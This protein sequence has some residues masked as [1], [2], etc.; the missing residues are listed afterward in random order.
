MMVKPFEDAVFGMK[1]EGDIEGPVQSEFG[2]HVIRLTG[3]QAG[4][5]RSLEEVKKELADEISRQKGARKFAESAE[6]FGNLAYE[7]PDSLKPRADRFS[8][9]IR[10]TPW[11]T[12]SA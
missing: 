7:Q 9:Q 4:K 1:K 3:I 2:F 12:K 10:T 6:T 11:V 5:A 8:V